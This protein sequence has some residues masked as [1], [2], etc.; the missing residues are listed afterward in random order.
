MDATAIGA[1][2]VAP[3][4]ESARETRSSS[5]A[6]RFLVATRGSLREAPRAVILAPAPGFEPDHEDVGLPLQAGRPSRSPSQP[7]L[8]LR[9]V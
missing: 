7:W 2:V 4:V 1:D 5:R 6:L 8:P 9:R 3:R